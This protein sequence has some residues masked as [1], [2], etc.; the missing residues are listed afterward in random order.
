MAFTNYTSAHPSIYYL[1]RSSE[2]HDGLETNLMLLTALI[3]Y[4]KTSLIRDSYS[5][6]LILSQAHYRVSQAISLVSE[7]DY[8]IALEL[9][10]SSDLVETSLTGQEYGL[11]H[12]VVRRGDSRP[13]VT[14]GAF[15]NVTLITSKICEVTDPDGVAIF[16]LVYGVIVFLFTLCAINLIK[17]S[18][19]D[20]KRSAAFV[21]RAR[22]DNKWAEDLARHAREWSVRVT[23]M[24][25]A[26]EQI[27]ELL[28]EYQKF[29]KESS[30]KLS[31]IDCT[32][33]K[34]YDRST[35]D[36]ERLKIINVLIEMIRRL[37]ENQSS[38][39]GKLIELYKA[40]PRL[41]KLGSHLASRVAEVVPELSQGKQFS[42]EES[43]ESLVEDSPPPLTILGGDKLRLNG[44]VSV[45][46]SEHADDAVEGEQW[47]K[48]G[49]TMR[50]LVMQANPT[51]QPPVTP[52]LRSFDCSE[53]HSL[54][55]PERNAQ[56]SIHLQQTKVAE[57]YEVIGKQREVLDLCGRAV[58][59]GIAESS[60]TVLEPLK[61]TQTSIRFIRECHKMF[62]T[63]QCTQCPYKH[64]ADTV[65]NHC[66][67]RVLCAYHCTI[68]VL[69][70][71]M[72]AGWY[73]CN[74]SNPKTVHDVIY[75]LL[76]FQGKAP[77]RRKTLYPYER[78]VMSRGE[79]V[80]S[81]SR[82]YDPIAEVTSGVSSIEYN[83]YRTCG[84]C[85]GRQP[86]L[87]R[88]GE[89]VRCQDLSYSTWFV[90]H[91]QT[92]LERN[93]WD[94][95]TQKQWGST[96]LLDCCLGRNDHG[97][98]AV[99]NLATCSVT[100]APA[101]FTDQETNLD[102]ISED[103]SED[104]DLPETASMI[105][106]AQETLISHEIE[107]LELPEV[108]KARMI[109]RGKIEAIIGSVLGLHNVVGLAD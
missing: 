19:Q 89:A 109:L 10:E 42:R 15:T 65:C 100:M 85:Q 87:G 60:T 98:A 20:S 36:E 104:L 50:Q 73:D 9:A 7:I 12:E 86:T 99:Y 54:H 31:D 108:A 5:K 74:L 106:P 92:N 38:L 97:S 75:H 4:V 68:C 6:Q 16:N 64:I 55:N 56:L 28:Q 26:H 46:T 63:D 45:D 51:L 84:G 27:S 23:K 1:N 33:I 72:V 58:W 78:P 49:H 103:S 83:L 71:Q 69:A 96:G 105:K 91:F 18:Y 39:R 61:L 35:S 88:K 11:I 3:T 66:L 70:V 107:A 34:S 82:M 52:L 79:T 101:P 24:A 76:V 94:A 81:R 43:I 44:Q 48:V 90:R 32:S 22:G 14:E 40:L 13:P 80:A 29:F 25:S 67:R 8:P 47:W 102:G 37:A 21:D 53:F 30:N 2:V 95:D 77:A 57:L 17:A 41:G 59:R 62:T 93:G